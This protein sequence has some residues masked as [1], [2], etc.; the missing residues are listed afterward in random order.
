MAEVGDHYRRID[1]SDDASDDTI[2]RVVG[3]TDEVTLLCVT[4]T[5]GRRVHTGEIHH[6]S[7]S[8]LAEQYEPADDP[9]SG[10]SPVSIVSNLFQGLYWNVR[11]FL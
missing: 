1:T 2:Y 11:K 5:D 10:F 3:A 8:T 9:D 6:V 4:D 7:P